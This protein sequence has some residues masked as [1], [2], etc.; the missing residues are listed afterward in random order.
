MIRLYLDSETCGLH[1]MPVLFQYAE[2]DG[3]I[4]LYDV[5]KHSVGETLDL[6]EWFLTHTMV[7][8]NAS[9]DFFHL[10]KAYTIFRLCSR[11]WIPEEHIDEIAMLEPKGQDGPCLKPAGAVDL[12]L[13]SR[14]GPFQSLMARED[15][16][17]RR[18]PK[19]LADALAEELEERIELDGIYFAKS[20]DKDAPRW[21]VYDRKKDGKLDPAFQGRGAEV[22]CGRRFEVPGRVRLKARSTAPFR[23]R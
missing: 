1:G 21:K 7:F 2:E 23:G 19:V 14:K 6:I 13:H 17:I 16:R 4:V 10:C 12:L 5:W 18:V 9:F 20:A 22:S 15:I 8:F 11:D 3:P